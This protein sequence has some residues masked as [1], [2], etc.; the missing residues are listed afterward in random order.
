MS[1][2]MKLST[3]FLFVVLAGAS[4]CGGQDATQPAAGS[5]SVGARK[6]TMAPSAPLDKSKTSPARK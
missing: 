2:H 1:S 5:I 6:D 3:I 4:G